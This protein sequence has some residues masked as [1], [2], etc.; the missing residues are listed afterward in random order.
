[1]PSAAKTWLKVDNTRM[2]NFSVHPAALIL[3]HMSYS[4]M[5]F[6]WAERQL[7]LLK[8]VT[9]AMGK[10]E[11]FW[12]WSYAAIVELYYVHINNIELCIVQT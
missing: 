11:M 2:E 3:R 10:I 7:R 1:M 9:L 8:W 12:C 6:E 5:V 4:R